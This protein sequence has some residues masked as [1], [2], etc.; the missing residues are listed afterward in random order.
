MIARLLI[1]PLP[2][3]RAEIA[4]ILASHIGKGNADYTKHP[5]VLYYLSDSKLGILEARKIKEHFSLKPY[6]AKGRAVVLEDASNLTIEGQNALLKTL[7]EPPANAILIL[8]APSDARFLPTVLS[9]CQ[10]IR[11]QQALEKEQQA[12]EGEGDKLQGYEKDIERL[13]SASIAERF[14]FVEKLKDREEFLYSLVSF[15]RQ[16]LHAP[17]PGLAKLEVKNFLQELL[18]AEEWA[19]Q[20][21]NIRAI[22]EYLM[23]V[24]PQ[25]L[26]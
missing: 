26:W 14:E 15:F 22:L 7:E 6:C 12:P 16:S 1:S 5:D 9:R 13:V 23:L 25:K 18:Q 11:M 21:V 3:R 2:E 19:A 20:N 17:R 4:K 24:M 10:V 8:G